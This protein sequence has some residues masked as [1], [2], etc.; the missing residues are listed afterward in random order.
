MN[1]FLDTNVVMDVVAKREAFYAASAAVWSRAA[2]RNI[3]GYVAG[4]TFNNTF[5]LTRKAAGRAAAIEAV[6][7]IRETFTLAP[8]TTA[9][10]DAAIAS[11]TPDFE[12]AVQ[13]F[14]ARSVG[15]AFLVTRNVKDFP[16][17]DLP[18]V[19]PEQFLAIV[20]AARPSS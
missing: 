5:Y 13:Y 17:G 6:K 4:I 15:A 14:S 11:D 7:A 16:Q 12:D 19:T 18:V 10:V 20:L 3:A 9:I 8:F 2:S 1:V